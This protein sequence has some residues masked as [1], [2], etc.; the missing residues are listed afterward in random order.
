MAVG[1]APVALARAPAGPV[2][3]QAAPG[4]TARGRA[5]RVPG[6]AVRQATAPAAMAPMTVPATRPNG[7]DDRGADNRGRVRG[8][9]DPP[10]DDR[11]ADHHV[12]PATGARVEINGNDIEVVHADGTKEEVENGRFEQKNPPAARLSNAA[13]PRPTLPACV[14]PAAEPVAGEAEKHRPAGTILPVRVIRQ[15]AQRGCRACMFWPSPPT[16]TAPSPTT[17]ASTSRPWPRSSGC[18]APRPQADPGHR[19]RAGRPEGDLPPARP[20]RPGGGR[21]R[22][23]ALPP[24]RRA[25]RSGL[26]R[27]RRRRVRRGP[28][29]RGVGPISVGRVDRRHLGAARDGRAGGDPRPRAWSCRSSSTRAR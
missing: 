6:P 28:A 21:E 26:G 25:R 27:R 4:P 12:N 19:P 7:A 13:R 14:P 17:A 16:T 24:G 18:A 29:A 8:N 20:V 23:A 3:A 11:R 5:G 1:A 2:R 10:G 15:S 9:D 22:R